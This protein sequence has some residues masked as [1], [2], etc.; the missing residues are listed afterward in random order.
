MSNLFLYAAT[1]LVWGST[2]IAIEFQLGAVA[3]EV[4]VFYR[5]VFAATLLFGWCLLKG[6]SLRFSLKSHSRFVML[7]LLLFGLNYILTY[8]A[9]QY[10]TSALSAICFSTMLW[11]NMINSRIFF[12][13][14]SGARVI[15]GSLFGVAGIVVLFLPQVESLSFSD[16]TLYGAALCVVGAALA[17]LGNMVSQ[18]AQK[19]GLPIIQSNAWGMFYGAVVTGAIAFGQGHSFVIVPTPAYIISMAYLVVFGSIVAFGAYLTLLGRIGAHRAGYA[20]IMFP[21]VALV[22]SVLFEGLEPSWNVLSGV[23][24]V[25]AGNFVIL[26]GSRSAGSRSVEKLE[27]PPQCV[28]ATQAAR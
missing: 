16:A 8:H 19:A 1:V 26:S 3:P 10:I 2:W 21:V 20:M 7:G 5:Y 14:R 15:V 22:L 25:I 24:M 13:V 28:A 4:S 17:S 23:M 6:K 11:M 18:G 12:G 9:Q 27:Q